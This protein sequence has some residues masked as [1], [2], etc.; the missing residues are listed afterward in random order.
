MD[1]ITITID[2]VTFRLKEQHDFQWLR[3]LGT[4]FA[5][6][7]EQ[8]SGNICF[9]VEKD[10]VKK[11]VKYAGARTLEYRGRP[12]D[13]VERLKTGLPLY[14]KLRHP[15]LIQLIEYFETDGGYAGVFEWFDG[16]CLHSHWSFPPPHKYTHPESP[17]YRY[18][19][20]SVE[21][22]L[23]SFDAILSF[24]AFVESKGFVAVDFYDGSILYDFKSDTTKICDIDFYRERPTF[25]DIGENFWGATRSKSPE[26]F[27]LNAPIDKRTNVYTMG[28]I[29]FGLF[30][31]ELDRSRSKWDAGTKAYETALRAVER[32]RDHRYSS[33]AQF[34]SAWKAANHFHHAR[35]EEMKYHEKFYGET[36]L[37]Q[38]GTWLSKPVKVVMDL[39]EEVILDNA[40]VLDLGCGVGRNSIPIAQRLQ[41]FNG[42]VDCV[43]LLPIA[44]Q[45]LMDHAEEYKVSDII[46]AVTAD[47]EY[48]EIQPDHYDYIVACSCLEHVTDIEAFKTVVSRMIEGTKADGI[49][50]ILMST[51]V[52]EYHFDLNKEVDGIIELNLKT[53]EAIAL[54]R[55]SYKGWDI[56]I[57]RHIPQTVVETKYGKDIEFRGNWL[58]FAARKK[59][60]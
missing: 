18:K 2:N 34:Y 37:F 15:N 25:N 48:Y 41:A 43:D 46:H 19:Q 26:E 10:G 27:V 42:T 20:L 24:H 7:D 36:T 32:D 50:C 21:K 47:A 33:V 5:V 16:E 31:G 12:E 57:E 49:N 53:Q 40:K 58:T 23:A 13:A 3:Q 29:A 6:F 8:D 1:F 22:R 54:L 52:R 56:L 4:P 45:K 28:A 59:L 51:E 38:P 11:F 14:E 30:G 60:I 44:I 35:L 17:F 55:D 39:L 9:G